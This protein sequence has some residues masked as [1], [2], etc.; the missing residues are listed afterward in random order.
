MRGF[1]ARRSQGSD[2]IVP[3]IAALIVNAVIGYALIAG[4]SGSPLT[5]G[6]ADDAPLTLFDLELP[7]QEKP[8]P[9]KPVKPRSQ[10]RDAGASAPRPRQTEPNIDRPQPA[11]MV[12]PPPVIAVPAP[13]LPVAGPSA[14]VA[15]AT[16]AAGA[17]GTGDG[18]GLSG[19]GTGAGRGTGDGGAFSQAR[20]TG[21]RF[22][23]SD[24]PDWLRGARNLKIGVRYSIGPSGYVDKCEI[25]EGSG[26]AEVDAMTC[27]VIMERYRFRPARDPDGYAVTEVRE[28]DYRWRVR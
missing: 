24:F 4:L 2:R 18:G 26:Y 6:A 8:V 19:S 1:R 16:G 7:E 17:G 25:I 20:Q 5:R 14:G 22:R 11:T 3:A 15:D 28:E 12:A 13:V 10:A 9:E 21:G 27:R 23:N